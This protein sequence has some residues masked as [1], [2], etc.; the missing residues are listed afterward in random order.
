[1]RS[2]PPVLNRGSVGGSGIG[3]GIG[4]QDRFGTGVRA[5]L[6]WAGQLAASVAAV[7][8]RLFS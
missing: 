8:S 5:V 4:L 6:P 3:L 2:C 7:R 1:M